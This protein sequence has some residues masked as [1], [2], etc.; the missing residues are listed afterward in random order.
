[1]VSLVITS[2]TVP[3][4]DLEMCSTEVVIRRIPE[5][6]EARYFSQV[7]SA[8]GSSTEAGIDRALAAKAAALGISTVPSPQ[9]PRL[10]LP[11][12]PSD[13]QTPDQQTNFSRRATS[14]LDHSLGIGV[15]D[16]PSSPRPLSN[17]A[18]YAASTTPALANSNS[19]G[20]P[21]SKKR[22]R[23]LSF[24]QYDKY[25]A[26]VDPNLKQPK[27]V[28]E[29]PVVPEPAP[30]LFSI[31]SRRSLVSFK[32]TLKTKVRWRRSAVSPLPI[33]C[34]CCRD[35]FNK[36]QSLQT[37]PC[38]H[39][40][41]SSC[42][43][44][45]VNQSVTDES[46]M[47]PRCC[48]QPI[49]GHVVKA[50]LDVEEQQTF[51]KAVLQFSTPWE[52]RIFCPNAACG[53]F[54]RPRAKI[55]PKHPFDVTCKYCRSR[56]CVMCKRDAHPLG[57]DCPAD[58][59]LD[60][61]LKMGEKSGW[62][63]CYKCRTLVELS[64][65][66]T[67][68]TCRCKAQFCYICGA[69]WDS[70]VG[71]PNYCN[72]E[73]ELERRRL[74]EEARMEELEAEK[75]AQEQAAL[76]VEADRLVALERTAASPEFAE[77]AETLAAEK[78]RIVTYENEAKSSL[79]SRHTDERVALM[80]RFSDQ[81]DKMRERHAKTMQH[82]EDRQIAAEMDLRATLEQR[83]R[84]VKI[85]LRHM[86]AYCDGL[87]RSVNPNS[88]PS[89]TN[90]GSLG[91]RPSSPNPANHPSMPTRVVTER[92][93][94]EL[95]QQYNMRDDL[96]RLHQARI[97]VLRDRQAKNMEDL[98]DRQRTEM[99][100]LL[101][102]RDEEIEDLEA[103]FAAQDDALL[104][105]FDERRQRARA[106]WALR[107]E[108]LQK[109]MENNT[110]L[111]HGPLPLPEWPSISG[112]SPLSPIA[113]SLGLQNEGPQLDSGDEYCSSTDGEVVKPDTMG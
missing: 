29:S 103:A 31:G 51:L 106:R 87:G 95:G 53:E 79:W 22:S 46:K 98:Q 26:H 113:T 30:S 56:V 25:L 110:G 13:H 68:M 62:R 78:E 111:R 52:A 27:F 1:M 35:D 43:K 85:R 75:E 59:E 8:S 96:E 12:E 109:T 40:Y 66:C 99:D 107:V 16:I 33:S 64:Q 6:S 15:S 89:T 58:F 36:I 49:P 74:E 65:G 100:N 4:N 38:G 91:S 97:N 82:L 21:L 50:V 94:R 20:A 112:S 76:A 102:Q 45:M 2:A 83:A 72:G 11:Y 10:S 18:D 48:T 3:S 44:I 90:S 60:E 55:D 93:L 9:P 63:R 101:N 70:T 61:V 34:I 41:C 104:C 42:L 108:I 86:E 37:L 73:E 80:E 28:K 57:Q 19:Q 105:V 7:F 17:V 47:P 14:D 88:S 67:H 71:C 69:V 54:I 5:L 39:T 77:L 84:S 23:N 81:V 32:R 24:S 92:D